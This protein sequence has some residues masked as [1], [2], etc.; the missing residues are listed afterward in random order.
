MKEKLILNHKDSIDFEIIWKKYNLNLA[1]EEEQEL[2]E[3]MKGHA[4]RKE[5]L[6]HAERYFEEGSCFGAYTPDVSELLTQ[7]KGVKSQ[8][9]IKGGFGKWAAVMM[10]ALV[11]IST[12]YFVFDAEKM[13]SVIKGLHYREVE[14][15]VLIFQE[16][17]AYYWDDK[18]AVQL[19]QYPSFSNSLES[20]NNDMG[21]NKKSNDILMIPQK[22]SCCVVLPDST[23]VW[24]NTMSSL[25]YP[26]YFKDD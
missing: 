11:S 10:I 4:D 25:R 1:M 5:F 22:C 8:K 17:S 16:G 13:E 7:I 6:I 26:V 21:L 14:G 23:Q 15:G 2:A 18:D 24:L 9:R 20:I 3:W 12:V 19:S